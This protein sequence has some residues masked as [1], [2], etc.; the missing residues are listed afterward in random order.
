MI[1]NIV[2]TVSR[3]EF[4]NNDQRTSVQLSCLL[5]VP[6]VGISFNKLFEFV[7]CTAVSLLG[8][9]RW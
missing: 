1:L 6:R 2:E 8:I 5:I 4:D 9:C 7:A 3:A